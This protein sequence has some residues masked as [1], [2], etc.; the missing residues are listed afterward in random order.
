MGAGM[1]DLQQPV[2]ER[3]IERVRHPDRVEHERQ[4]VADN[5]NSI[6]LRKRPQ[7]HNDEQP[8]PVPGRS[9]KGAPLRRLRRLLHLDRLADLAHLAHD[10]RVLRVATAVVAGED[11]VGFGR[12]V[13]A[14]EPAR[15][16]GDEVEEGELDEGVAGLQDGGAA[17]GP[18]RGVVL[19]AEC[20]PSGKRNVRESI[21]DVLWSED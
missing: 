17:P 18:G 14:H 7:T 19:A 12:A 5:A 16:F 2:D 10:E 8:L 11:V 15:R 1:T 13:F 9:D 3:L 6:P 4:V 20:C 21:V